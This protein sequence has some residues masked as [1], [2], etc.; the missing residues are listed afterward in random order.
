MVHLDDGVGGGR[1]DTALTLAVVGSE[2]AVLVAVL[3]ESD[4]AVLA[5]ARSPGVLHGPVLIRSVVVVS[6]NENTVVEGVT[7]R[8]RV[9]HTAGVQLER[10]L[11]SLDGNGHGSRSDGGF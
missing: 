9:K 1:G 7:A 8:R 11:V 6:D 5:P 10:V 3:A 4:V 2:E